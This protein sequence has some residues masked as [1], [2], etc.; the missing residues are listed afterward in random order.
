M[1]SLAL[2]AKVSFN[3]R[4]PEVTRDPLQW[5]PD[6]LDAELRGLRVLT[7]SF[8]NGDAVKLPLADGFP[9][10]LSERGEDGQ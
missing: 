9:F 10:Q 3:L 8:G 4:L 5:A 1:K 7:R 6:L 2:D